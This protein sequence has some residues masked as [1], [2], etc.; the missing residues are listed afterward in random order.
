MQP[1]TPDQ[2]LSSRTEG[3]TDICLQLDATCALPDGKGGWLL[4]DAAG[5][6]L[7]L[8][9]GQLDAQLGQSLQH[10]GGV[11]CRGMLEAVWPSAFWRYGCGCVA[12]RSPLCLHLVPRISSLPSP[13]LPQ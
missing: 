11:G 3:D 12:R 5:T 1:Q 6:E 7:R 13:R 9:G 8:A 2:V 4:E 10:V